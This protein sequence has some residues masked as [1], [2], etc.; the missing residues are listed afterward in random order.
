M[1]VDKDVLQDYM[2][3]VWRAADKAKDNADRL[4]EAFIDLTEQERLD[5]YA[6]K[7]LRQKIKNEAKDAVEYADELAKVS[8][9]LNGILN[10]KEKDGH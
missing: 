1:N 10:G 5:Y 7:E 6:A 4:W 9:L 2:S 8:R 3:D